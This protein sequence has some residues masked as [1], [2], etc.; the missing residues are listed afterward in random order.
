[1]SRKQIFS[2]D[3]ATVLFQVRLFPKKVHLCQLEDELIMV[4]PTTHF[5]QIL[6]AVRIHTKNIFRTLVQ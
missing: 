6:G 1:M 4:N 3:P 2:E 5:T